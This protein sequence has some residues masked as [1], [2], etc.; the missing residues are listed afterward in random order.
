MW[1]DVQYAVEAKKDKSTTDFTDNT[2][3]RQTEFSY[4]CN[5]CHPWLIVSTLMQTP[6]EEVLEL[7]SAAAELR[8]GGAS[9]ETV[10]ADLDR[11]PDTCRR[12]ARDYARTWQRLYRAAHAQQARE[13]EAEARVVL[14]TLLRSKDNKVQL[15]AARQLLRPGPKPRPR[16]PMP[17]PPDAELT[18]FLSQVRNLSDAELDDML[19][20]LPPR[21]GTALAGAAGPRASQ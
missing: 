18:A 7:M 4:S 11:H 1:T 9:W 20:D 12:W 16:K 8:A 5:S 15:A 2:D 3:Q 13:A 10:G 17:E 19:R 14:R 6:S 21:P